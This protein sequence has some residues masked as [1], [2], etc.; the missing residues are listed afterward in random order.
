MTK[1]F[2]CDS[3]AELC[4]ELYKDTCFANT[5]LEE[6]ERTHE[7]DTLFARHAVFKFNN[8]NM[9]PLVDFHRENKKH[10]LLE[11][12]NIYVWSNY[13]KIVQVQLFILSNK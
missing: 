9:L 5:V 2:S 1:V 10:V 3:K 4:E 12:D 7:F 13:T 11:M 6:I 8:K